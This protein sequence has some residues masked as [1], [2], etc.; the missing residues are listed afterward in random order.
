MGETSTS[1]MWALL[2]GRSKVGRRELCQIVQIQ[3]RFFTNKFFKRLKLKFD[4]LKSEKLI[5]IRFQEEIQLFK[6]YIFS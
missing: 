4:N 1:F 6:D 3:T 2:P 5:L